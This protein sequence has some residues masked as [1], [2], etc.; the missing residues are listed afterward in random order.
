[1]YYQTEN[2]KMEEYNE[3]EEDVF[4]EQTDF[5]NSEGRNMDNMA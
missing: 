2:A 1:M 5:V 4:V 3:R